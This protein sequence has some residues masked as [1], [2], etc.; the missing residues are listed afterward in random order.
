MYRVFDRKNSGSSVDFRKNN[1]YAA[2]S[3]DAG[4]RRPG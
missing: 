3:T 2:A 4:L 1:G